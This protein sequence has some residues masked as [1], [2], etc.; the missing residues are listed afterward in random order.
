[1]SSE[2]EQNIDKYTDV[3]LKVG[4]NL[5]QG[6][7]LLIG[8]ANPVND[9]TPVELV[10]FIQKIV[11][12]AYQMGARFVEVLWNDPHMDLLRFQ[13][14][15][16]DSFEEV[17]T[18]RKEVALEYATKGDAILAIAAQDP[19]M[20]IDQ[21]PTLIMTHAQAKSILYKPVMELLI[22]NNMNWLVASAP[23]D[24]W[25]ERI[26]NEPPSANLKTKLWNKIFQICRVD[27]EDPISA[28]KEHIENLQI[29]CEYLNK[30]QYN[31]LR[32]T[33]S[34]TDLTIG[35]AKNHVWGG[36][37]ITS[38]NGITCV[39]NLPTEEI[40]T[41]P[42]KYKVEGTVKAT[43]PLF[44]SGTIIEDFSFAFSNGKVIEYDAGKGK[45]MLDNLLNYDEGAK[46][47]GEVAIVPHSSPISQSGLLFYNALIDENAA[48]H[49]ALGS[50]YKFCIENGVEMS[51]EEF[52]KCGGNLS[53][54]HMDFMIGS[55][56]T[57]IDGIKEDGSVEPIMRNGEWVI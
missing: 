36:G 31:A 50:A 18:W 55:Q 46:Y 13:Y 16:R 9:G 12:K 39:P 32:I 1:M 3:I 37:N 49:I 28:W 25:A 44:Y 35:L 5:Q 26:F 42:D 4:L 22:K 14:A 29:R 34:G 7:R 11:K 20:F 41:I 24:G 43:K 52:A 30:K 21:D 40:F 45:E 54:L 27:Q 8:V 48:C 56:E 15:P 33:A 47:L 17:T 10:S 19:E 23:V 53:M 6:Q 57:N 51:D 38:Q 2:F